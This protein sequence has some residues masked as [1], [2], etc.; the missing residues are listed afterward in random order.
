MPI[1]NPNQQ[2][3]QQQQNLW[4]AQV[5]KGSRKRSNQFGTDL[6][7]LLRVEPMSDRVRK[8]IKHSY[9]DAQVDNNG[10]ILLSELR[11]FMATPAFDSWM[12]KFSATGL[13]IKC[14]R[15]TILEKSEQMLDRYGNIRNH[16][17]PCGE[18]CPM[19]DDPLGVECSLGC[20]HSGRLMFYIYDLF[21]EGIEKPCYLDTHSWKDIQSIPAQL[22]LVMERY[23]SIKT[24]MCPT[25][26]NQIVFT[27]SRSQVDIKRPMTDKSKTYT[28]PGTN[29]TKPCRTGKKTD[30][31]TWA[32]S[33]DLCPEWTQEFNNWNLATQV[34]AMGYAPAQHLLEGIID[35]SARVVNAVPVLPPAVEEETVEQVMSEQDRHDFKVLLAKNGWGVNIAQEVK[36]QFGVERPG[37]VPSSRIDELYA[38][39]EDAELAKTYQ[40]K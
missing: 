30:G 9:P 38:I 5:F 14:D 1:H 40:A 21:L 8:I 35:V 13:E 6:N 36:K 20:T 22:E 7:Q 18:A 2:Q 15:H 33:L 27:L 10:D 4:S 16:M 25:F 3:N 23:G 31:T 19:R 34:R 11:I 32:L 17:K 28:I 26:R 24:A 29:Q 12:Q 37:L 39:A